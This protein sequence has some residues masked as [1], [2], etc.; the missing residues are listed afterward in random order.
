MMNNFVDRVFIINLPRRTDRRALAEHELAI[1]GINPNMVEWVD[2]VDC[3][4]NAHSGCNRAHRALLKRVAEGPW[5]RVLVLEDDFKTITEQDLIDHGFTPEQQV[6]KT[7]HAV[8]GVTLNERFAQM[9]DHPTIQNDNMMVLYLGG[10]YGENPIRRVSDHIVQCGFIQGT[11]SYI[12]TRDMARQWSNAAEL[13]FPNDFGP[14]DNLFGDIQKSLICRY[15][16]FQPRLLYQR[17][18]KSDITGEE[19]SYLFSHT[20]PAHEN[21]V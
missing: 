8:P 5:D 21:M 10:G 14:I 6:W 3:P 15:Y 20:D 4:V 17:K 7:F 9:S 13:L 19:N 16:I 18:V 12:I 2:G 1:S 11:A